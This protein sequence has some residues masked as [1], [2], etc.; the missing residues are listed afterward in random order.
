MDG[1]ARA[2]LG[3]AVV[4]AV[5]AALAVVAAL[6]DR[7]PIQREWGRLAL[8]PY[9]TGAAAAFVLG[10][11]WRRSP[12]RRPEHVRAALLVVVVAGVALVPLG[13]EVWWRARDGFRGHVQSE[14][15]VTE[16]SS[17]AVLRGV[18]PYSASF[19]DGD[20]G[21]WP[22]GTADHVPYMPGM[23]LFGLPYALGGSG[24]ATDARLAFA[25]VALA[26]LAVALALSRAPSDRRLTALAVLV[27]LP[28]GARYMVGGGDDPAVLSMMLLSLAL[29]DRRRPGWAG[30][31][32]GLAAAVKQT[33]WP[34][35][36][37][38]L[39]VAWKR[40]G[41]RGVR[42]ALAGMSVVV[43]IVVPFVLWDPHA[44][45]EDVVLF[46]LGLAKDPTLAASPTL[47]SVLAGMLPVGKEVVAAVLLLGV[48]AIGLY[49]L[50]VRPPT[51][52]RGA[53]ERAA[54]VLLLAIVF[55]TAG[56]FGY[57]LYPIGLFAWARL[58][59]APERPA[60][61]VM[62]PFE[63]LRFPVPREGA[64]AAKGSGL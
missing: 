25:L 57:L 21:S 42:R 14:V 37:F 61:P 58:I 1:R 18:N 6:S 49:A 7:I 24:A 8:G 30:V 40:D 48:L 51:D 53:A 22:A 11:V 54:L 4:Y 46:P 45:V 20:L 19:A 31:V 34:L 64:R 32:A 62:V 43:A 28:T 15:L 63:A 38:L 36:P 33:A 44:F 35:L 23:F 10:L 17:A 26:L 2:V 55:A 9:L 59:L 41:R 39:V 50:F 12:A 60:E 27:A 16:Q 29:L 52:S 3:D 13:L 56:R 47:G 5:G